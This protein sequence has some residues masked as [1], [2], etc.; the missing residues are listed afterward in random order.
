MR[1]FSAV[2]AKP[3]GSIPLSNGTRTE[4]GI[5]GSEDSASRNHASARTC[6]GSYGT[7]NIVGIGIISYWE[8]PTDC[9]VF[10]ICV[11]V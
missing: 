1:R 9:L 11:S 6:V 8:R 7:R 2:S 10:C 5:Q 3:L 4:Q